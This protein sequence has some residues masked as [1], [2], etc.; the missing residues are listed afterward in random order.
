[1][2][3]ATVV[4]E[5][6]ATTSPRPTTA[7]SEPARP[8]AVST[9]PAP[10]SEPARPFGV[11]NAETAKAFAAA[12]T[13]ESRPFA[14]PEPGV[15]PQRVLLV[16]D[17][18]SIRTLLKIYLMARSF[19]YIEAES[20]EAGLKV[21]ET[22]PVD[23][24]LTDFHMDGMNGAD[25]AATVRASRDTKVAKIPILMMTG[26]ANAAEVR[27][28]GQKAGINAFVR[29]PVSCAQLMTLVDTILPP[30]KK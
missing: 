3:P 12:S 24:I 6:A 15:Q 1:M 29:K 26:D 21:L 17:S 16:D 19:E 30:A 10:L 2:K 25:F 23:L 5:A 7:P 14:R 9:G 28:K 11:L 20:A 4:P 22:Q 27:N 13:P 8:A 18:R